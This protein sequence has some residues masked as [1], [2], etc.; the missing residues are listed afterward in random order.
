MRRVLIRN[1]RIDFIK[2]WTV[3]FMTAAEPSSI[4]FM[5]HW[6]IAAMLL[7]DPASATAK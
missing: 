5:L 1:Q 4:A 6:F 7:D 3:D 2:P